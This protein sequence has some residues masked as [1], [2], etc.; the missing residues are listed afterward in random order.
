M[1]VQQDVPSLRMNL[2][3]KFLEARDAAP[4]LSEVL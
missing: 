1:G 4:G 3:F 2:P